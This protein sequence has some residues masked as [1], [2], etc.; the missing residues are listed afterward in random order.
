MS[1]S[2]PGRDRCCA[3]RSLG[4]AHRDTAGSSAAL[5]G[6]RRFALVPSAWQCVENVLESR[7]AN[8]S[9]IRS[10]S[11]NPA[12]QEA[13]VDAYQRLSQHGPAIPRAGHRC[14][15]SERRGA[16]RKT[17]RSPSEQRS[18]SAIL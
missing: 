8:D 10:S 11:V 18:P 14:A 1:N 17:L 7:A 9:Q 13:D 6:Y 12:A 15:R 4:R 3:P 5:E 16:K 2:F